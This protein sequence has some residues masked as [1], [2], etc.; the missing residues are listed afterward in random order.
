MGI[1]TGDGPD[2]IIHRMKD[3]AMVSGRRV[4]AAVVFVLWALLVFAPYLV[5]DNPSP[6][7]LVRWTAVAAI[8]LLLVFSLPPLL[9]KERRGPVVTV[10]V[11]AAAVVVLAW[12]LTA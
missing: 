3:D 2:L 1:P 11:A 4:A 9:A 6:D 12:V 8:A 5:A 10:A 7:T